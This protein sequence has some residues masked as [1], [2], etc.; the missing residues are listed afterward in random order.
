MSLASYLNQLDE[1]A[2]KEALTRCCAARAWVEAMSG[3]RPF[4]DDEAVLRTC[5]LAWWD[6]ERDDWREAFA[7]HPQIG[8]IDSL[9][10]KYADTRQWAGGEQSGVA[11]AAEETL[12]RLAKLNREYLARFGYIFIV[13]ATGKSAEEMLAILQQ[14]LPNSPDAEL[15]IAA[16]EQLKITQLRLRKLVS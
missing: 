11:G 12:V 2:L 10:A 4:A 14:R 8:D 15:Q 13:C 7:A 3:A 6:L 1:I 5:Q 9:R 16:S